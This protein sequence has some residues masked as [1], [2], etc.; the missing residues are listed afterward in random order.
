MVDPAVTWGS[1]SAPRTTLVG[2][3]IYGSPRK[4]MTA[5][6]E[7]LPQQLRGTFAGLADPRVIDHLVKLGVTSIELL[8]VQA[9]FDDRHLIERGADQFLGPTTPRL[10]R[11][12]HAL[13]VGPAPASM[14]SS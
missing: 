12:C 11:P 3:V 5:L 9:F 10:L 2:N 14:N 8:P 13:R 7:D 6:N 4:G 1:D